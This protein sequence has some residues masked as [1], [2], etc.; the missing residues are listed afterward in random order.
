MGNATNPWTECSFVLQTSLTG[1]FRF[2]LF[3]LSRHLG[4]ALIALLRGVKRRDDEAQSSTE[5]TI[6]LSL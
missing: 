6:N 5:R 4:E 3:S 2:R 1:M